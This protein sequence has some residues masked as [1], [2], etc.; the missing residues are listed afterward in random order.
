MPDLRIAIELENVARE[1]TAGTDTDV[2]SGINASDDAFYAE[3]PEWI[4]ELNRLGVLNASRWRAPRC[5]SSPA[6][7]ASARA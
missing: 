1:L 4:A 3:T 5:T 2:H 7:A 6:S